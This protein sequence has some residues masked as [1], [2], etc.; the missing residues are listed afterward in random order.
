MLLA[1]FSILNVGSAMI[2]PGLLEKNSY[3]EGLEAGQYAYCLENIDVFKEILS[4]AELKDAKKL[5]D[6]NPYDVPD[7]KPSRLGADTEG[8]VI[9]VEQLSEMEWNWSKGFAFSLKG[10]AAPSM[11]SSSAVG[12]EASPLATSLDSENSFSSKK[13]EIQPSIKEVCLKIPARLLLAK[14]IFDER[15]ISLNQSLGRYFK[16]TSMP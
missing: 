10:A 6:K 7:Y 4:D 8:H 11:D 9:S 15:A 12:M 13:Y 1:Y 2:Q 14:I 5:I 16:E 3:Y